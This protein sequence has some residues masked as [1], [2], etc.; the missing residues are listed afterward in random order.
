MI[1]AILVLVLGV[2]ALAIAGFTFTTAADYSNTVSIVTE[3]EVVA[4]SQITYGL[5]LTMHVNRTSFAQGE[6]LR[7][8]LDLTNVGQ[9]SIE[10][11]Y[12]RGELFDLIIVDQRGSM[13]ATWS[14]D[15]PPLGAPAITLTL[16]P[17]ESYHTTMTWV[18]GIPKGAYLLHG[19]VSASLPHTV[20]PVGRP[21]TSRYLLETTPISITVS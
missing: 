18:L 12:F 4:M 1:V 10:V 6:S 11:V 14:S 5:R 13:L 9:H 19:S 20:Y 17:G 8:R 16:G 21:I 3:S 7:V 15:H 2:G